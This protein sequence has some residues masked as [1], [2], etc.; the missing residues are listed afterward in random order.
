MSRYT[1]SNLRDDV[2]AING[3]LA[4]LNYPARLE[5]A[6]RYCYQAIDEYPV[7]SAGCRIGDGCVLRT[8]E[9]GSSKECGVAAWRYLSGCAAKVPIVPELLVKFRLCGCTEFCDKEGWLYQ[10]FHNEREAWN[11]AADCGDSVRDAFFVS[12]GEYLI[13][14]YCLVEEE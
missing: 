6:G 14:S 3:R 9:S 13:S 8:V 2:A 5:C 1:I 11:W 4:E 12:S 10:A 7:D